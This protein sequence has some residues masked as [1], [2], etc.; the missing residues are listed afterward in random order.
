MIHDHVLII[1]Y[2]K[3]NQQVDIQICIFTY[4]KQLSGGYTVY[5]TIGSYPNF[6]KTNLHI[7][8]LPCCLYSLYCLSLLP[9]L[10]KLKNRKELHWQYCVSLLHYGENSS[11]PSFFIRLTMAQP[12]LRYS[13]ML[14]ICHECYYLKH[15]FSIKE[16]KYLK[17][18]AIK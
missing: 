2:E 7:S 12:L 8:L 4:Y 17:F 5:N 9:S 15:R 10:S 1:H 14:T 6:N 18:N 13:S 16:C 11:Q 3:Y